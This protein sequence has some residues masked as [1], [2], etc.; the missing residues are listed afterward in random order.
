MRAFLRKIYY[1]LPIVGDITRISHHLAAIRNNQEILK[2]LFARS[3][4]L[5]ILSSSERYTDKK[6][7]H[8]SER[9]VCSQN[10][11]DGI[12]AEIMRRLGVQGKTFVEIGVGGGCENNTSLLLSL[13]WSGY[14]I[15][16]DPAIRSSLSYWEQRSPG[17]LKGVV[18]FV[19]SENINRLFGELGVPEEFDFLSVDIDQNTYYIWEALRSYKPKVVA[20]EYNS[21]IPPEIEWKVKYDATSTWDG[22]ANFGAGLKSLEILGHEKGYAL[23]GC[24]LAGVNAFFVRSDLVNDLFATPFTAENHYEPPRYELS[25]QF[26]HPATFLDRV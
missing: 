2:K 7:L 20:V 3:A 24:D 13:G 6:R 1:K 10:G 21:S 8:L 11:E 19:T 15:D 9:K 5:E 18:S 12:I 25:Q 23:I 22:S 4:T 26:G 17:S 14:W 16:G